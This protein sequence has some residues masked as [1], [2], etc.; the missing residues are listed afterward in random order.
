[1]DAV[2]NEIG[3]QPVFRQLVPNVVGMPPQNRMRA[4]SEMRRERRARRHG[5]VDLLPRRLRMA[6]GRRPRP[7][8]PRARYTAARPA[9]RARA[10]QC[11][12]GFAAASCQRRNSSKSGARTHSRGCAPR[13]P[14][15]GE[16]C[17]PSTW[18]PSMAAPSSRES[19][20]RERFSSAFAM[21]AGGPVITVGKKRVTPVENNT[22]IER[23]I[24]SCGVDGAV[25]VHAGETVHLKIDE[26]QARPNSSQIHDRFIAQVCHK[27]RNA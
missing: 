3:H 27:I 1:M 4:V 14:S 6:D 13:G 15:S 9:T 19:L 18:K 8:R 2:H 10:S 20:A 16:M 7:P 21:S 17:G 12:R 24:S 5:I 22:R 26:A 11:E 25:V 23:A